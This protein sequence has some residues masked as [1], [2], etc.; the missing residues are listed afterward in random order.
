MGNTRLP[1]IFSF[2]T[3][4]GPLVV[5]C[6]SAARA[7]EFPRLPQSQRRAVPAVVRRL[8]KTS[9]RYA[10]EDADC[11]I[12]DEAAPIEGRILVALEMAGSH[13][14]GC[15]CGACATWGLGASA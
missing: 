4:S 1:E 14:I 7:L 8:F 13:D 3:S 11:L 9:A 6:F 10:G 5:R 15:I 12:C 2:K